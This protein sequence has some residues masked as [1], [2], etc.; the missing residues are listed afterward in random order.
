MAF[1][2]PLRSVAYFG[3]ILMR[4]SQEALG[5]FQHLAV[6]PGRTNTVQKIITNFNIGFNEGEELRRVGAL[7]ME[8]NRFN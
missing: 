6:S 8:P 7:L 1:Y 5:G 4:A 3:A 2:T